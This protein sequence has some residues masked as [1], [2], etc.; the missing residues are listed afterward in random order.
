[1]SSSIYIFEFPE[2]SSWA[3]LPWLD[4]INLV[5]GYVFYLWN[6][7]ALHRTFQLVDDKNQLFRF[8]PHPL[9]WKTKPLFHRGFYFYIIILLFFHT[10]Q[11][12]Q[13]VPFSWGRNG[14]GY[15]HLPAMYLHLHCCNHCH[16]QIPLVTISYPGQDFSFHVFRWLGLDAFLYRNAFLLPWMKGTLIYSDAFMPFTKKAS[17][18]CMY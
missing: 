10:Q 18:I 15:P 4:S 1:M 8:F 5:M 11:S 16:P 7:S 14:L 3:M 9:I 6:Y 17:R 13:R 12:S 2:W